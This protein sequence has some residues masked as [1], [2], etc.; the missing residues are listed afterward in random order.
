MQSNR[1]TFI[2]NNVKGIQKRGK[3]LTV[4]EYL[5]NKLHQDGLLFLQE[6]HSKLEDESKWKDDFQAPIF[7]S[8][9]TSNSCGVLIAYIG[10]SFFFS[11]D[12]GR[13]LILDT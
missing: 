2:S 4:I 3:R 9:G 1:L 10:Q 7:F 11:N 12:N 5:K 13:I 6:T 8:H